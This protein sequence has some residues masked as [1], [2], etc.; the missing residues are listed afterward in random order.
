MA[1]PDFNS[2]F[3]ELLESEEPLGSFADFNIDPGTPH[4]LLPAGNGQSPI[5]LFDWAQ[6]FQFEGG[7]ATVPAQEVPKFYHTPNYDEQD[8]P[9]EVDGQYQ[10]VGQF[11]LA[12]PGQD[13]HFPEQEQIYA[14]PYAPF[15]F[16][17]DPSG[18]SFMI[19]PQLEN[20]GSSEM[21]PDLFNSPE[22]NMFMPL[23]LEED[24][25]MANGS[26][27]ASPLEQF[28]PSTPDPLSVRRRKLGLKSNVNAN[29]VDSIAS[30]ISKSWRKG[31]AVASQM[32]FHPEAPIPVR[33]IPTNLTGSEY[34]DW[35]G[36]S[37]PG[38]S[39]ASRRLAKFLKPL[40]FDAQPSVAADRKPKQAGSDD[41]IDLE[42]YQTPYHS[43]SSSGV[44]S[45][46]EYLTKATVPLMRDEQKEWDLSNSSRGEISELV[47]SNESSILQV[48]TNGANGEGGGGSRRVTSSVKRGRG[49]PI[50][51][52]SKRQRRIQAM[53]QPNYVPP[54][55]GRPRTSERHLRKR[56]RRV[57]VVKGPDQT[58]GEPV[59]TEDEEGTQ[60]QYTS[61]VYY[62]EVGYKPIYFILSPAQAQKIQQM[63]NV[64][65]PKQ[66]WE[67]QDIRWQVTYNLQRVTPTG[68]TLQRRIEEDTKHMAQVNLKNETQDKENKEPLGIE[69]L[70]ELLKEY[71]IPPRHRNISDSPTHNL[72]LFPVALPRDPNPKKTPFPDRRLKVITDIPGAGTSARELSQQ[73]VLQKLVDERDV[74]F[75]AIVW[76]ILQNSPLVKPMEFVGTMN[77]IMGSWDFV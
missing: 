56:T 12:H 34:A 67:P 11:P 19:D 72:A 45:I 27:A 47:E 50:V 66:G 51:P 74:Y 33:H 57:R 37:F 25:G 71:P 65:T 40:L 59:N 1:A 52:G 43:R 53:A 30:N 26:S 76:E 77:R 61:V 49:R 13:F 5:G 62:E 46:G 14:A 28:S 4:G 54:K 17:V 73:E 23:N 44:S 41:T 42:K 70:E 60:E 8:A 32:Q 16:A 9:Y 3:Q 10:Y 31:K 21:Y 48:E 24:P 22:T 29:Q 18:G 35:H 68:E 55:R 15:P 75:R 20:S 39:S 2:T 38:S 64:P 69:E 7:D 58:L 36:D 6:N 63:Y